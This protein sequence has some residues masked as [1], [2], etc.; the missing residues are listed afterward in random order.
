MSEIDKSHVFSNYRS[1]FHKEPSQLCVCFLKQSNLLMP[2]AYFCSPEVRMARI[3]RKN[4]ILI[5]SPNNDDIM[6][7]HS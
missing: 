6:T 3:S 1:K 7:T 2:I 5:F 4:N